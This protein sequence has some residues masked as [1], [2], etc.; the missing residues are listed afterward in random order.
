MALSLKKII[1]IDAASDAKALGL[2]L[3]GDLHQCQ[4]DRRYFLDAGLLRSHCLE[5]VQAAGLT[6]VGDYFH[7]FGEGGGVTGVVVL[8]ESHLSVHTWPEKD[9]VTIDVYVCNYSTNN[10]VKARRLFDDLVGTF[11]SAQPRFFTVDRT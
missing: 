7:Q 6:V 4:G 1:P 3:M 10:R 9:A 11:G 2:H 8:A 5:L